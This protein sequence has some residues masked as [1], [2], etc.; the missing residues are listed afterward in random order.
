MVHCVNKRVTVRSVPGN[1]I[2][3][4]KKSMLE[5]YKTVYKG[6]EGEIVEKKSRFIATVRPVKTEEEALAFINTGM[7]DTTVMYILWERIGNIPDAVMTEN[8]QVQRADRCW[9]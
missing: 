5:K 6:G 4:G 3:R 8:L 1:R 7:P 9:M 2:E